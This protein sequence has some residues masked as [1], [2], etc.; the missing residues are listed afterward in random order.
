MDI[1]ERSEKNHRRKQ[2]YLY[3][4]N[5]VLSS[6]SIE[7]K[8]KERMLNYLRITSFL[9]GRLFKLGILPLVIHE[10]KSQMFEF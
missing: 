7:V 6:L 10:N 4:M 3:R 9:W 2:I 8:R 5:K 1:L